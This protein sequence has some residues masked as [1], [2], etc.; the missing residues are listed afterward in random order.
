MSS[1]RR[2]ADLP[3]LVERARAGEARAI[4]RLISLVEDGSPQLPEL[5]GLLAPLHGQ[6]HVVGL[7]GAPGVGKSTST[8]A[9]ISELRAVTIG[10][11]YWR[12]TRPR[13]SPAGRCSVTGSG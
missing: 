8:S 6:A 12:S 9:L 13:R 3:D 4:G 11:G 7:T 2:R 5:T 10:S 1:S